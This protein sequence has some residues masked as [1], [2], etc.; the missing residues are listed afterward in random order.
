MEWLGHGAG[1]WSGFPSYEQV[2]EWCLLQLPLEVLVEVAAREPR[3]EELLEGAA[4]LFASWDFGQERGPE[5]ARLPADLKRALLEHAR[6]SKDRDKR[7]RAANAFA[8]R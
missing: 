2:P 7:A 4:R 5:L 1:P 6:R 8:R 3:S